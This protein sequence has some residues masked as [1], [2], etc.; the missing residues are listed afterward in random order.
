MGLFRFLFF[1][2]KLPSSL[3]YIKPF[4]IPKDYFHKT[5]KKSSILC[6]RASAKSQ[7]HLGLDEFLGSLDLRLA[8]RPTVLGT[9]ISANS[10]VCRLLQRLCVWREINTEY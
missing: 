4:K 1:G 3:R 10:Q 9:H 7:A 8:E 2:S 5:V 6:K